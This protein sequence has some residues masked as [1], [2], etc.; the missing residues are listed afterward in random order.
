[1]E[2]LFKTYGSTILAVIGSLI[3]MAIIVGIF[4]DTGNFW[5]FDGERK[6]ATYFEEDADGHSGTVG[7]K[8]K[9]KYNK[10][11]EKWEEDDSKSLL[12]FGDIIGGSL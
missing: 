1:M 9:G 6:P 8:K 5:G 7:D 2:D 11:T 10:E 4:S 12:Q 3:L